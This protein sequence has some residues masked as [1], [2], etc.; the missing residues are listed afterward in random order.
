M[1]NKQ[2]KNA[3]SSPIISVILP[4]YNGERYIQETV[5]SVQKSNFKDL[6]ILLIDDGSKDLSKALCQHLAKKYSNIRFYSFGK[7]RG[8]SNALNFALKKAKGTYICR[9]NQDDIM[10]PERV[11]LQLKYLQNHPDVVAVGSYITL[12]N[13]AGD[14]ETLTYFEDDALIRQNWC[15]VSPF[16]DPAIMYLKDVAIKAGGYSQRYWPADDLHL[17]YRIS[18]FGKLANIQKPLVKMRVHERS[19]SQIFFRKQILNTFKV[20]YWK[21]RSGEKASL[22]IQFYWLVQLMSGILL[23]PKINWYLYKQVKSGNFY[24]SSLLAKTNV[25][26]IKSKVLLIPKRLSFSVS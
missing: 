24:F 23:G 14:L 1:S 15:F 12:F 26:M 4:V 8:L 13:E 17:W 21:H 9:L 20:H 18:R 2:I 11:T 22:G 10:M 5:E 16:A 25:Q 7:N 6:E 19:A 3:T